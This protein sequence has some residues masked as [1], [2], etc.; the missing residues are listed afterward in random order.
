MDSF[1][2]YEK[3]SI[4]IDI[5]YFPPRKFYSHKFG[6]DYNENKIHDPVHQGYRPSKFVDIIKKIPVAL[7]NG[8]TTEKDYNSYRQYY[9]D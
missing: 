9:G 8:P 1:L 5:Q 4:G 2:F 7:L 6:V 3:E